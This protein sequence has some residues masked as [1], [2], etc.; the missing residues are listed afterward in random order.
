MRTLITLPGIGGSGDNHWETLWELSDPSIRRFQPPDWNRPQLTS[1]CDALQ[2]AV[3]AARHPA[4]L[5][6][7]SL[8]CLLVAHWA[9]RSRLSIAGVFLVAVPDPDGP[10]FPVEADSFRAVPGNRLPF[11]SLIV[12][13]E[14][15]PYGSLDYVRRRSEQWGSTMVNIGKCGHINELCNLGAW[16]AGRSL[17]ENFRAQT[18]GEA[19]R[20]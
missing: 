9:A 6:A 8:A 13:S 16:P 1:W 2:N 15:D 7:H 4:I 10:V 18:E 11:Q 14:D 3:E 19:S 20:N 12:A 17:L 5:I